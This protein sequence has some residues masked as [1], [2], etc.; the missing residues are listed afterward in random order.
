VDFGA[1]AT[2]TGRIGYAFDRTLFYAKGGGAWAR[3][4]NFAA[5]VDG[6]IF[7]PTATTSVRRDRFGWTVGAGVEHALA[8][9]PRW[10]VK[11]E[12]LYM[13][14]G[15]DRSFDLSGFGYDHRNEVHTFKVGVNYRPGWFGGAPAAAPI[16]AS[17]YNWTGFYVGVN[18]G[19]GL[20]DQSTDNLTPF[21]GF[22]EGAPV[23]ANLAPK[24]FVG[25]GQAG[26]NWQAGWAVLGIEA[27]AG[28][29]GMRKE[30]TA[31]DDFTR[32]EYGWYG[33]LAGRA[34]VA[35]DRTLLY[36]KFGGAWARI[37]NTASDLDAGV[38]DPL[39][40]SSISKTHFGWAVGAGIEHA[41]L[42]NWSLKGEYLYLGF[43]KVRSFNATPGEAFEHRNEVHTA[44][45]G[46]N[47]KFGGT[48][49]VAR[50]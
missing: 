9:A 17:V 11:A 39:D 50:Y 5:D 3:V 34:G 18:V 38:F 13:N 46:L 33:V 32:A 37:K 19:Y 43:D 25:G 31:I 40:F 30:V 10:S 28:Y 6:A 42:P 20:A 29:L 14:F 1:Y 41:F 21:G 49:V 8:F 45:I 7:D 16:V 4:D 15:T 36:A 44:K 12:Y 27:E 48:A 23:R 22:D 2:L 26:Y 24:G 35:L 47:Y